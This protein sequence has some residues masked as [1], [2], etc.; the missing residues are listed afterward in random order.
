MEQGKT[1]HTRNNRQNKEEVCIYINEDKKEHSG[2]YYGA[3]FNFYDNMIGKIL[4]TI[5]HKST[6]EK[7]IIYINRIE[8]RPEYRGRG[9]FKIL[10]GEFKKKIIEQKLKSEKNN[11]T[12]YIDGSFIN[13]YLERFLFNHSEK[14]T[15]V[16][17]LRYNE[18]KEKYKKDTI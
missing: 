11:Q 8:I 10:W 16:R 4:Y 6:Q 7:N 1:P 3:F 9:I 18:L 12:L 17:L 15:G 14:E 5:N 2:S 13:D